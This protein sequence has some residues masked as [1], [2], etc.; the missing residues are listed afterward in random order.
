MNP[1]SSAGR[2]ASEERVPAKESVDETEEIQ[3]THHITG[4]HVLHLALES[5]IARPFLAVRQSSN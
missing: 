1:E 3:I 5:I 4:S 2:T